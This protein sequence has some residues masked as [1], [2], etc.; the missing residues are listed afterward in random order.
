M[1]AT[2]EEI[3]RLLKEQSDASEIKREEKENER[4]KTE[5]DERAAE[6]KAEKEERLA[7]RKED[8]ET[9]KKFIEEVVNIKIELK[10]IKSDQTKTNENY[11]TLS[12]KM[13][14]L[15]AQMSDLQKK[16]NTWPPIH[17][18][19]TESSK[20]GNSVTNHPV[21]RN[22]PASQPTD[23]L[24]DQRKIYRIV[25]EAKKT[26]GFSP[27]SEEDIR[28]V[29]ED[30][31]IHERDA[32]LKA[33]ILDFL[34]QEMSIPR[35]ESDKLVITKVFRPEGASN[36]C[37]KMFVEFEDDNMPGLIYKYVRKLNHSSS[38]HITSPHGSKPGLTILKSAHTT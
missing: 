12:E 29:M 36:E 3:M 16:E 37:E 25:K 34:S 32:G 7:E 35:E 14:N 2:L 6:K 38:I 33:T 15:E 23:N 10:D 4:R 21:G 13:N 1:A 17:P 26:L 11:N 19:G 27:I 5:R 20:S 9:M 24:E 28:I 30:Q 31:E 18:S 8:K 22:A